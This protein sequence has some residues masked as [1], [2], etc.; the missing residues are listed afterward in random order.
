MIL[1]TRVEVTMMRDQLMSKL[2]KA[3]FHK[4]TFIIDVLDQ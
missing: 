2:P 4:L 1:S 3:L